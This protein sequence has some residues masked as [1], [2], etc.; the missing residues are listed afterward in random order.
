M[1]WYNKFLF[2]CQLANKKKAFLKNQ[3]RFLLA[4]TI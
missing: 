3:E 1:G 4:P 2:V